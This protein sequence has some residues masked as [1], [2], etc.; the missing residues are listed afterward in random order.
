MRK[1]RKQGEA[2][3]TEGRGEE[4]WQEAKGGGEGK[5]K[6]KKEKDEG[7][8]VR[9]RRNGRKQGEEGRAWCRGQKEGGKNMWKEEGVEVN[10]LDFFIRQR[11][12]ERY[13]KR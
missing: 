3:R 1:G 6:E 2:G 9:G 4:E 13:K 10:I 8:K 7:Q 11:I 5:G 12:C